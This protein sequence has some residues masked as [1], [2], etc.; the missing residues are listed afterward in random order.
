MPH[1]AEATQYTGFL[2]AGVVAALLDTACGYAAATTVGY[3]LASN[4]SINCLAPA[5]GDAFV[6]RGLVVKAG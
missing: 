3:V 6:A 5:I 2:H 1:R 4:I